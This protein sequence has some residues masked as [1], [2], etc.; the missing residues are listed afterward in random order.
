L[1]KISVDISLKLN[2]YKKNNILYFYKINPPLSSN[3]THL[4]SLFLLSLLSFFSVL[5][6]F[7]FL[8]LPERQGEMR[9]IREIEGERERDSRMRERDQRRDETEREGESEIGRERP[10]E[11]KSL[12]PRPVS[13]T[14]RIWEKPCDPILPEVRPSVSGG[15]NSGFR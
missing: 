12:D 11:P 7:F 4:S 10:E 3:H 15:P 9:E 8:L 5:R 13:Q 1:C 14:R 6:S 2:D